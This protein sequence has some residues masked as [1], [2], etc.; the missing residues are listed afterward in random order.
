MADF[1]FAATTITLRLSVSE[2]SL[3]R[4]PFA[5]TFA[6]AI[7]FSFHFALSFSLTVRTSS[8]F[9]CS[10]SPFP[11]IV[12]ACFAD[13]VTTQVPRFPT[14][15]TVSLVRARLVVSGKNGQNRMAGMFLDGLP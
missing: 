4:L 1:R 2:V 12:W 5:F 3:I 8:R 14:L 9:P 15:K 13:R 7:S 6:L 11:N 10:R